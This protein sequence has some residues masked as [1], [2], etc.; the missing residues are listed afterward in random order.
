MAISLEAQEQAKEIIESGL[1]SLFRGKV[2]FDTFRARSMLDEANDEFLQVSVVYEGNREELS[3]GLLNSLHQE[4]KPQLLAI[5]I[6]TVPVISYID[7]TEDSEWSE[8]AF[9]HLPS[10]RA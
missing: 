7:K 9:A 2:R 5:G 8:I 3:P 4:I 1:V 10:G 6:Q